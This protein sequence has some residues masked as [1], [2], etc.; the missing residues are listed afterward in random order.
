MPE[1]S[2]LMDRCRSLPGF[3]IPPLALLAWAPPAEPPA[4]A[5]PVPVAFDEASVDTWPNRLRILSMVCFF[6]FYYF[7]ENMSLQQVFLIF[8]AV[9]GA[10]PLISNSHGDLAT[11]QHAKIFV[12]QLAHYQQTFPTGYHNNWRTN[13][14][15][16]WGVFPKINQLKQYLEEGLQV[17][18]KNDKQMS[19]TWVGTGLKI[20][21]FISCRPALV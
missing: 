13:K 6:M 10:N 18:A 15:S 7:L 3:T 5:S 12:K 4:A 9:R 16:I 11:R 8:L 2:P 21:T 1:K 17:S 19:T 20:A 14:R